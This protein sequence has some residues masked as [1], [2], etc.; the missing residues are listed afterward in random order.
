M[1]AVYGIR[2]LL[3]GSV[4]S[5]RIY[6]FLTQKYSSCALKEP[7]TLHSTLWPSLRM[8][9]PRRKLN[10]L[11]FTNPPANY[12]IKSPLPSVD[13][14]QL[15]RRILSVKTV[16][17][18]LDLFD[19]VKHSVDT[20]NKVTILYSIAKIA[21]RDAK[22]K[23]ALEQERERAQ[24]KQ[25][26]SYME[27]LES[28]SLDISKCQL[29]GL[30]NVMWALGKIEEKNHKLVQFCE[31]EI[32]SRD[33]LALNNAG[34]CQIVNGCA[35]LDLTTSHI[36]RNLEE[37]ILNGQLRIATFDNQLLSAILLSFAKAENG[38]VG[39]FEVFLEEIQSRDFLII[40][41]RAL[42]EF[43]W[44]FAKRG[45]KA[46]KLFHRVEGEILRRGT[47]D[48]NNGSFIQILWA[49]T[50]AG[51]GS[52]QF[53]SF[54]DNQLLSR[55]VDRFLNVHLLEIVWSFA[56]RKVTKA[57]VFDLVKKEI[58][59]R[60]VHKFQSH[61]LL[62]I[63]WSFVSARRHDHQLVAEIES[64]LYLRGVNHFR[65]GDLC[66]VAWSLGRARK[67]D[68]KLFDLIEGE[69]FQRGVGEFTM[70]E[71]RMLMRGFIEAK[72]GSKELY[73][74]LVSSFLA[75]DFCG[76]HGSQIYE[77]VWCFSRAGVK[78]EAQFHALEKEIVIKGRDFFSQ[79]QVIFLKKTFKK[80]G[81]E[82][83]ELFKL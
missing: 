53:F 66:Q 43:V 70:K 62:L 76:L 18:Q 45:F 11:Y 28:I 31:R 68:S 22:Q 72:R 4:H 29:K 71:K 63:L 74:L 77:C 46:E 16:E 13:N 50:T 49:F 60:T 54:L 17:H 67:S 34:I 79:K 12:S 21:E 37:V 83:Q 2:S 65:N 26:S 36:F 75:K 51:K 30:V 24:Q 33:I 55:G 39:L 27:L 38:S 15:N 41:N 7:P 44:S 14:I 52:K 81:K 40:D 64:E 80:L 9:K 3:I 23:K 61:E 5:L 25:S 32:L 42:A 82:S 58:F 73:E 10:S 35:N 20:V 19:T 59:K 1:F 57:K 78:A 6:P 8:S 56:K 48:F 47:H 69:V